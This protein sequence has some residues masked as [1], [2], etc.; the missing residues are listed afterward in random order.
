MRKHPSYFIV[1]ETIL[2][3]L[4]MWYFHRKTYPSSMSENW[5][6]TYWKGVR[7]KVM[8]RLVYVCVENVEEGVRTMYMY[9]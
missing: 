5:V 4:T 7:K 2:L 1:L 6:H 3:L 8:C 9:A